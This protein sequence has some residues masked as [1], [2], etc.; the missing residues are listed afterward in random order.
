M[1]R[2][3]ALKSIGCVC[4]GV[5]LPMPTTPTEDVTRFTNGWS[6]R[7]VKSDAKVVPSVRN[8]QDMVEYPYWRVRES[9]LREHPWLEAYT[10]PVGWR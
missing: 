2:R 9:D 6:V 7:W 3:D 1:N 4:V 8:D 10:D 5:G